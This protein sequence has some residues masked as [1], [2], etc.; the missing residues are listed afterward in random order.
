MADVKGVCGPL[1]RR[2]GMSDEEFDRDTVAV[3]SDLMTVKHLL[4]SNTG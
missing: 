1:R 3:R 2:A 4:E